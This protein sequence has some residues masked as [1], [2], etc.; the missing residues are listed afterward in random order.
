MKLVL[1]ELIFGPLHLVAVLLQQL[2]AEEPHEQDIIRL[3]GGE[4]LEISVWIL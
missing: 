2:V 1:G 3:A 4:S